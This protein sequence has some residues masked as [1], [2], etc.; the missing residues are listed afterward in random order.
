M[1]ARVLLAVLLALPAPAAAQGAAAPG[2][3][4]GAVHDSL[5]GGGPLAAA[6]VWID[7]TTLTTYTGADG[8]FR[9]DSVPPG[10][11]RVTFVHPALHAQ[12]IGAP[13]ATVDV[14][15]GAE[16]SV[17]LAT[18]DGARGRAALC[19]AAAPPEARTG[20]LLGLLG[21]ADSG[22][23]AGEAPARVTASWV[24]LSL[25]RGGLTRTPRSATAAVDAEGAFR[26]CD[27]PTDVPLEVRAEGADGAV[28]VAEISFLGREVAL[29]RLALPPREAGDAEGATTAV[30]RGRVLTPDPDASPA[31]GAE[32]RVIAGRD[33]SPAVVTGADGALALRGVPPGDVLVEARAI[34]FRPVRARVAAAAGRGAS[35]VL[36][37]GA[38]ATV[39]ATSHVT[40][41]RPSAMLAG[42]DAR[43]TR[44]AG[45]FVTREM[46]EKWRPGNTLEAV[47]MVPGVRLVPGSASGDQFGATQISVPRALTGPITNAS[48]RAA[49]YV[50]GVRWA[51][52][53]G[54]PLENVI[55]P[56]DIYGIEVHATLAG[57][58]PEFA[59][60]DAGCGVVLIW[61]RR[62]RDR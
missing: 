36:T 12:R 62:G 8:R 45:R 40:A 38:D 15:P 13:V 48:C 37:L 49:V 6:E 32:V 2:R 10:R 46:L 4:L 50:D 19:P 57:I 9:F 18:P 5:L 34:G 30:L 1:R 11:H 47:A 58:P 24:V 53:V 14:A 52:D 20:L 33:T 41:R 39:L 31:Q 22:G 26:L 25:G 28:A 42:F 29:T 61:T 59:P 16:T 35:L 43:R 54:Q 17:V 3:L 23:A 27:V 51:T 55:R 60:P 56:S 21:R 7:G 44:G